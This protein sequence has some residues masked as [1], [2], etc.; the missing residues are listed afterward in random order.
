MQQARSLA[1]QDPRDS[2][3]QTVF[4]VTQAQRVRLVQQVLHR[5]SQARQARQAQQALPALQARLPDPLALQAQRV[6]PAQQARQER[7]D[8]QVLSAQQESKEF[9]AQQAR[10]ERPQP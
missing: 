3:A 7:L 6:L 2:L 1:Q 8:L 5:Q 9:R 10:P 4:K